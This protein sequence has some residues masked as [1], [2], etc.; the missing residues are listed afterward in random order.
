[1][2]IRSDAELQ[3]FAQRGCKVWNGT[4]YVRGANDITSF[5]AV[6]GLTSIVNG[7]LYIRDLP[8]LTSL[9]GL[10]NLEGPIS[11]RLIIRN[12]VLLTNLSGLEG[13]TGIGSSGKCDEG[14]CMYID[15]HPLLTSIEGLSGLTGA[16]PGGI[17]IQNNDILLTLKGL[18]GLTSITGFD[19]DRGFSL[20][21]E[22]HAKLQSIQALDNLLG[23][24]PGALLVWNNDELES[25]QGVLGIQA[26][27]S[28]RA[29]ETGAAVYF[30]GLHNL[31][32][33]AAEKASLNQLCSLSSGNGDIDSCVPSDS[34]AWW[35]P[36][37][38]VVL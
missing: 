28:T 34:N 37:C 18:E 30:A 15:D 27:A 13:I 35:R 23:V 31:C 8:A 6:A 4:W 33:T 32:V 29:Y 24:L 22:G 19:D 3:A 9:R 36:N 21:I 7:Q 5:E 12:N 2:K 20:T 25:L 14:L 16:I 17:K 26:A 38:N 1:M 10:R 11:D